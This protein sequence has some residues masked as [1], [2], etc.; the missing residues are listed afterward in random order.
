MK[1]LNLGCGSRYSDDWVNIDFISSNADVIAHNLTLGIPFPNNEFNVVY[2]S[3]LLEHFNKEQGFRFINECYRVLIPN[4]VLRIVVPDL[5]GIAKNYIKSIQDLENSPSS[6]NNSNHEWAVLEMIDQMVRI[7]SGGEIANYWQQN[8]IINEHIVEHR[9]GYEFTQYRK[10]YISRL[11]KED[12]KMPNRKFN[13]FQRIQRK[14]KE[15]LLQEIG[16]SEEA[17][18]KA[19]FWETGE[20]HQW[21]YDRYSLKKVLESI[22]FV[23][24]NITNAFISRIPEWNKYSFLDV[25]NNKV[26]KPDS[27]FIEANK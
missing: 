2:H 19:K 27:L 8:E 12:S 26:R 20:V 18:I 10:T 17:L 16:L 15:R 1:M 7:K 11:R 13:L 5:E 24:I 6:V 25:E 4:G 3:H 21:M 14:I 23:N 22:G 9:V